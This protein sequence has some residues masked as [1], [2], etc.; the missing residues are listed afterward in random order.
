MN[1]K[2]GIW[3][4]ILVLIISVLCHAEEPNSVYKN[5]ICFDFGNVIAYIPLYLV[6]PSVFHFPS[7]GAAYER[8]I[9]NLIG[10]RGGI[11]IDIV[12]AVAITGVG[13]NFYPN[14][15]AIR[16]WYVGVSGNILVYK[17]YSDPAD[18][19][20]IMG[21]YSGY[22]WI[23]PSQWVL[24]LGAGCRAIHFDRGWDHFPNFE[25]AFGYTF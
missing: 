10:L 23:L 13:V 3:I 17:E 15:G 19:Y 8:R 18:I 16:G 11:E 1:A 6:K 22:Q 9:N 12:D 4:L 14:K 25:A 2:R 21:I 24:R 20:G 7:F 5:A